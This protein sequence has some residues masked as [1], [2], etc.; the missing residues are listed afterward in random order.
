[1]SNQD[2][3]AITITISG[4][5]N[6][7][8]LIIS[9]SS[10]SIVENGAT[11]QDASNVV[12]DNI[13]ASLNALTLHVDSSFALK[14]HVDA[15]HNSLQ[16]YVDSSFALKSHV[17]ASHNSLQTYVDNTFSLETNFQTLVTK[18]NDLINILKLGDL[19]GVLDNSLNDL[20]YN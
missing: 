12:I 5:S 4:D 11:G 16:T 9:S 17:D 1:M 10:A 6:D 19:S 15:S 2:S 18:F 3:S 14:S 13:E 8:N 7:S 20:S